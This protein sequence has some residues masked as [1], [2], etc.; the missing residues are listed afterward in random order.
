MAAS[1]PMRMSSVLTRN[2]EELR[3]NVAQMEKCCE[4][5]ASSVA[6]TIRFLNLYRDR[7]LQHIRAEQAQVS[8]TIEKA[9]QEADK[10][11]GK[12]SLPTSPLAKILLTEAN[13][14]VQFFNYTI[15]VPDWEA[16]VLTWVA[17]S[18]DLDR[19]IAQSSNQVA[20]PLVYV[21]RN[22]V[23]IFNSESSTLTR[24]LTSAVKLDRGS[25]YVWTD[26]G[27]FCAGGRNYAGL[28]EQWNG[29]RD[30]YMLTEGEQWTMTRLAD[31]RLAR[32]GQGLWWL[33]TRHSVL[34]FGGNDYAGSSK[35]YERPKQSA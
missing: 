33:A 29:L 5:I 21:E 1:P 35:S 23:K 3:R 15:S 2:K 22:C 12:S 34:V 24:N 25:R 32:F 7:M 13:G 27:L 19:L 20:L 31:M 9:I 16:I 30:A 18:T 10:C 6:A 28:G 11:L 26:S 8:D 4:E 17:Y 14:Q